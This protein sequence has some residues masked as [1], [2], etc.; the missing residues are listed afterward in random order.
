MKST[1]GSPVLSLRDSG[2]VVELSRGLYQLA[3]ST[4][5]GNVDFVA[6]CARAPH[7]M[8]S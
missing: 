6:V 3:D 8:V 2:E 4:G 7:G 1:L 5:T